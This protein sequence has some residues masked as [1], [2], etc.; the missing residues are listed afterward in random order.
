MTVIWQADGHHVKAAMKYFS[1]LISFAVLFLHGTASADT[2]LC[3]QQA[4]LFDSAFY[5]D[6]NDEQPIPEHQ[7]QQLRAFASK[8]S[9]N[10]R[11]DEIVALCE[12]HYSNPKAAQY[13]YLLDAEISTSTRGVVRLAAEK[14]R[15]DRSL[16]KLQ[17]LWLTPETEM[18]TNRQRWHTLEFLGDNT[19][20]YSHKYRAQNPP[21]QNTLPV[22]QHRSSR[23]VHEINKLTYRHGK[24]TIDRKLYVNG[25]IVEQSDIRLTRSAT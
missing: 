11:G 17:T 24:L 15:S 3:Q 13:E 12:G 18:L 1:S 20:I 9:G 2:A 7:L 4:P 6:I 10:W 8:V 16:S 21:R 19:L 14:E 22:S 5:Y 25:A 23:L